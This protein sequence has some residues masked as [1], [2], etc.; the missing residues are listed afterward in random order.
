MLDS[1]GWTYEKEEERFEISCGLDWNDE[2]LDIRIHLDVAREVAV[3]WI[4]LDLKVAEDMYTTM[5]KYRTTRLL[6]DVAWVTNMK[7]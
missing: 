3:V 1:M 5:A 6:W 7:L 2:N 4:Y